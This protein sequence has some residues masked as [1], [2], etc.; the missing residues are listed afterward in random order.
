MPTAYSKVTMQHNYLNG[1][2]II[3]EMCKIIEN[4]F[5]IKPLLLKALI[6][7]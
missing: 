2:Y 3:E 4:S 7:R 1:K 5:K 6:N